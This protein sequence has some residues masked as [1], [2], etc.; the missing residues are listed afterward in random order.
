MAASLH[1][2]EILVLNFTKSAMKPPS[3]LAL[4]DAPYCT[5]DNQTM[6]R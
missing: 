3:E 2:P 1:V 6:R 4:V 5:K